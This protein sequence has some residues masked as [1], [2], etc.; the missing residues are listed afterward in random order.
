MIP[1]L[2]AA[3][4]RVVAPD[5]VGFGRSDKPARKADYSYLHHVIWMRAWLEAPHRTGQWRPAHGSGAGA[6]RIPC[7]ACVCRLQ[8]LVPGWIT[9]GGYRVWQQSVPGAL[10]QPHAVTRNVGHFLQER[11]GPEVAAAIVV[12]I[13]STPVH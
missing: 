6:A 4:L 7:L 10:G 5:L 3:G 9:Q 2:L 13:E 12:F 11:K 8:Q 1:V